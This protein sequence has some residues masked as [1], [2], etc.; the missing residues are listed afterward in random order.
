M[1]KPRVLNTEQYLIGQLPWIEATRSDAPRE[2]ALGNESLNNTRLK[3][4]RVDLNL[5]PNNMPNVSAKI[6]ETKWDPKVGDWAYTITYFIKKYL[7]P[8]MISAYAKI[9]RSPI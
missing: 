2:G 4:A 9:A 6:T 8:V 5:I 7:T 3:F 1:A